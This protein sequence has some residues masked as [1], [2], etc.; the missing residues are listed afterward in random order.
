[1]INSLVES[2]EAFSKA[3]AEMRWHKVTQGSVRPAIRGKVEARPGLGSMTSL[4][5]RKNTGF[6][7]PPRQSHRVFIKLLKTNSLTPPNGASKAKK[8]FRISK[9]QSH[10][11]SQEVV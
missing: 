4:E 3:A 10:R 5:N 2:V 9:H 11:Q 7:G 6:W 1:V 8:S